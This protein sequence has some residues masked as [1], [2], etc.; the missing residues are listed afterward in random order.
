MAV[1]VLLLSASVLLH[2]WNLGSALTR[3]PSL[4]SRFDTIVKVSSRSEVKCPSIPGN[5]V[6]LTDYM[7]LPVEQYA[8]VPLPGN[9]KLIRDEKTGVFVL[10]VPKLTFFTL[11]CLPRVYCKVD[12]SPN[13]DAVR[14]Y[15]D[16]CVLSGSKYVDKL[17]E[18]Y[19]FSVRTQFTWVDSPSDKRIK[20]KSDILVYVD[21]PP[22]FSAFPK[23][24]LEST[25]NL[26]MQTALY[27]IEKTF[28]QALSE[29][30]KRW[31]TDSSY[32]ARRAAISERMKLQQQQQQQQQQKRR[33][34]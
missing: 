13:G 5:G 34:Q 16:K 14:I 33:L 7:R 32:R 26:V 21:P 31:A 12:T 3:P 8:I 2:C 9:A 28:I 25:G 6:S 27:Y 22:P 1:L 4:P 15:S 23:S 10:T 19:W 20:S 17:N 18:H 11:E 24:V 29:D 30:Y